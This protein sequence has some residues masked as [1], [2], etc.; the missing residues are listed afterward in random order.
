MTAK[1]NFSTANVPRST[2]VFPHAVVA[3]NLIFV[4]GTTGITPGTG[5]L[6]ASFEEQA[7]QAF[8]NIKTILEEMDSS[9][10]KIVKTTV[11]MVSG[12]DFS[13]LNKVYQEVFP[14]NAPAR[15][16]PQ[17]MPFP[18]GILI[19]VECIALV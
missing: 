11:F 5:Q 9:L 3:N 2:D 19:S 15:S 4:S 6:S 16:T 13:I 8:R 18:A 10:D 17:V 12:N 1:Q 14:D 7:R